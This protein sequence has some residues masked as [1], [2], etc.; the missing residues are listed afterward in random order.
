MSLC[1]IA[2]HKLKFFMFFKLNTE[3]SVKSNIDKLIC[4]A[5][6]PIQI[7]MTHSLYC[8]S[9]A[10]STYLNSPSPWQPV[11]GSIHDIERHC[12][13]HEFCYILNDVTITNTCL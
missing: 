12:W 3:K 2:L 7:A 6:K 8:L 9:F 13:V 4:S 5:Q 10:E 11:Q 1:Y